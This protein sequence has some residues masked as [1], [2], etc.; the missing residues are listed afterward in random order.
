[1]KISTLLTPAEIAQ[2]PDTDLASSTAVVFDI[3]RATS[4]FITALA[5]G[6]EVI[7]P[8]RDLSEALQL[9]EK[10]PDAWLGGERHGEKIA[11]FQLGNSPLEYRDLTGLKI[12]STTTNG[13][14]ALRAASHADVVYVGSLLN[15]QALADHLREINPAHLS[16]ICAGTGTGFALEDGLAA[17]ALLDALLPSAPILDDASQLLISFW[18]SKKELLA[19]TLAAS[20]NGRR[21]IER[22]RKPEVDWC[23]QLNHLP[24]VAQLHEGKISTVPTAAGEK[25]RKNPAL[26]A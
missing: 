26:E 8:A 23:A 12:I 2:L 20:K 21:L 9:K 15:L 17:G 5:H 10:H 24:L 11:G 22:G 6:V 13:T 1:M 16:L 3:L 25:L 19:T 4:T 7:F 18:Q 14:L